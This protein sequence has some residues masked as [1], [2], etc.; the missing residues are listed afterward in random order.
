MW[1]SKIN[2]FEVQIR[3]TLELRNA[4][5]GTF[6]ICGGGDNER[7]CGLESSS[8]LDCREFR[9]PLENG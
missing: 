8:R 3:L 5:L 7:I 1:N 4:G 6:V 9:R 2:L